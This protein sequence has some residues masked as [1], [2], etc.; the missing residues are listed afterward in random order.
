MDKLEAIQYV[1]RNGHR[2]SEWEEAALLQ[3]VSKIAFT[4]ISD[5]SKTNLDK[6]IE[7]AR[8]GA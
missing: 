6:E 2:S 1:L 3:L 7:E 4:K 5:L 8:E